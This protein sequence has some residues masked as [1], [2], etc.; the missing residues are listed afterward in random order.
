MVIIKNGNVLEAEENI[1]CHQ[2]NENGNMGGGLA[3]QIARKYPNVEQSY[4]T[5]CQRYNE[6]DI[7]LYGNWGLCPIEIDKYII[8]CF[9]QQHYNTRYDL[10]ESVFK[11]IK[12]YAKQN[13]LTICMPWK[14]G[15][16][17]A[18]GEWEKVEEI[19]L[20]IFTDYD[21]TI[22]RYKQ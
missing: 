9:T 21:I 7:D 12:S 20:D 10:I 13:N 22:Y 14:Y 4:K 8:N 17:I 1:I 19:L 11:S 16:G 3:L 5:M 6:D 15:C 2:V 18:K